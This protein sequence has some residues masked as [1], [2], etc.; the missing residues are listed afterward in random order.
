MDSSTTKRRPIHI[1]SMGHAAF[2]A[3]M[4]GLGVLGLIKKDLTVVWLPVPD[5]V[6]REVLAY[7]CSIL[8]LATGAGYHASG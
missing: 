7:L 4:I 5:G 1:A 3:I 2:A 8:S 6:P